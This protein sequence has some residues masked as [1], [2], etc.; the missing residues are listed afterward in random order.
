MLMFES[1]TESKV[2]FFMKK[3]LL[4]YVRQDWHHMGRQPRCNSFLMHPRAKN[5]FSSVSLKFSF[6]EKAK[7]NCT[8][9]L[10]ALMFY[11]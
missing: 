4:Y 5:T 8:I 11:V 3:F 1:G 10:I 9:V 2:I 6:S 7:K